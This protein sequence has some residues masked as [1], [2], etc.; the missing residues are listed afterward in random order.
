MLSSAHSPV[1]TS[2]KSCQ[3]YRERGPGGVNLVQ[4]LPLTGPLWEGPEGLGSGVYVARVAIWA[5]RMATIC[6]SVEKC[7]NILIIIQL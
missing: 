6:H 2:Q 5:S 4:T 3:S 7:V 1:L